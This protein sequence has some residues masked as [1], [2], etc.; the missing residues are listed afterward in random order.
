M[1]K[2]KRSWLFRPRALRFRACSALGL[3]LIA[4]PAVAQSTGS[5]SGTVT[6]AQTGAP[7]PGANVQIVGTRTG[8]LTRS[9]GTYRLTLSAGSHNIRVNLIGFGA[10]TEAVSLT[11]GQSAVR[12][13]QL[14]P[15]A[16]ALD[17]IVALGTRRAD[18]TVT[19]SPVPVDVLTAQ[20]I[21]STG[22]T[23][24]AQIIQRLAPSVN[25]PRTAIA[26]GSDHMRPVTLRGLAPDQVLVL[27]NGKRR[28]NTSLVHV[29]GTVGR[30][31]TSVD[32]NAIPSSAIERIE[33]L[34]DG[35]AAQ[36]GSDAIAGVVNIVLKSGAQ[37]SLTTTLGQVRSEEDGRTHR[38]GEVVQA[39]G[40]VGAAIGEGGHFTVSGEFRD[41]NRTNRAYQDARPQYL[42]GDPRNAETPRI[43][44]WQGDG[45]ARDLSGFLNA[46]YPLA[47]GMEL[48]SFG[49]VTYREGM[50]AGFFRRANDNRTIRQIHP[51]GF[52]PEIGSE[53]LDFS[54]A[55]GIRGS[56]QGWR[57]DLSSV[58]GGNSFRFSVHNSN[59]VT[60]GTS[61]P[62]DFYAGTLKFNQWTNNLDFSRELDL[63]L[64]SPVNVAAG[65]EFR[66]DNYQI[67]AGEE[68]S[69]RN[70]GVLILDGPAAGAQGALGAQVFPGFR[71]ADERSENRNNIAAYL[72][73][74]SNLTPQFLV[75]VA[76]R[77]ERYS[78]FGSTADGK[79]AARLELI[80]AIAL[81]GAAGTGFRAP[82]LGQSHFSS[83]STNFIEGVPFDIRTFPV[84]TT[85]AQILGA[86][87][88]KPEQSLN[89]SAGVSLEPLSGLVVT[90]DYYAIDI[91][92]RIVLSGNFTQPAVRQLFEQR[93][94]SG[95]GGGRFFTN[96][97]DTETRGFDVVAS[98]GV[99][100]DE[101][102]TLRLTGG[103]N[104]NRTE[105][106]RIA[107][108]PPELSAFQSTLFDRVEQ[109]RI[110][111]GQPRNNVNLTANYT[112]GGIGVN[113][114]NQR[115]GEVTQVG[116]P[117]DGSLDQTF[118]A[119]WITDLDVSYRL[120]RRA[121]VA[122]GA[123]NLLDVYPD[124]WK[125]F[126]QGVSGTLTTSGIYRYPGGVSPFGF[127]GRFVYLRLSYGGASR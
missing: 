101:A 22:L 70:G 87:E 72:D 35:A 30:G 108:T 126:N 65:A 33:V 117:A 49:G 83:T 19:N 100:L 66:L 1:S 69:Y 23:E 123:N 78:D 21:E 62:T 96:A 116:S 58:Y 103:Y 74:E 51:T 115:F 46:A 82:S 104:Q 37:Q 38:D 40:T 110:E 67:E 25:F 52:L 42:A 90:A 121:R 2:T 28:H 68:N 12:N 113:L 124:E 84:N 107:P 6:H 109:G 106:T 20:V 80:P 102:G 77:V 118:S 127:N 86:R 9:D 3:L 16:V 43:S 81:R 50:A 95:V 47:N 60:L 98:Y 11:A 41:R 89:L 24:T 57:W 10:A 54:G 34:R 92:D 112:L 13:F 94:L 15:S 76:G 91:A 5:V 64:A 48:Y 120:M 97:I 71:P 7:V 114:H 55:G 14:S 85:E 63:G 4:V 45:D 36:Y 88:L 61:S 26:D 105:V 44:S 18:R 79:I 53:I 122:V 99:L 17:E 32:L 29:N 93:G 39:G 75:N 8:T 59:N 73:L 111:R 119:K 56:M 125:D 27:I 31:S